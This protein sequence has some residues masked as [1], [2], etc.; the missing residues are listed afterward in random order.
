MVFYHGAGMMLYR[1]GNLYVI[2]NM[3]ESI[4]DT[5]DSGVVML[6]RYWRNGPC[7]RIVWPEAHCKEINRAYR[8]WKKK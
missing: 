6:S 1:N 8:I 4:T 5:D 2:E 7:R 3:M